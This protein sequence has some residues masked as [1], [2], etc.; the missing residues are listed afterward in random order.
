MYVHVHVHV[1]IM[2]EIQYNT[3]DALINIIISLTDED[4]E[5]HHSDLTLQSPAVFHSRESWAEVNDTVSDLVSHKKKHPYTQQS[6]ADSAIGMVCDYY[7]PSQIIPV[8]YSVVV[9]VV[10]VNL[11]CCCCCCCLCLVF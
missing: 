11:L 6:D 1:L 9:V 5:L 3:V 7:Y 4:D 10:V 8:L 2:S